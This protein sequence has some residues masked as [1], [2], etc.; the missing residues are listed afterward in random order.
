MGGRKGNKSKKKKTRTAVQKAAAARHAKFK[1][2]RVQTLGGKRT[3][4]SNAEKKRI[5]NAGYSVKGY[6]KAAPNKASGYSGT[7]G[8]SVGSKIKNPNPKTKQEVSGIG[9]VPDGN[10]YG[11]MIDKSP[12]GDFNTNTDGQLVAQKRYNLLN[13]FN[14]PGIMKEGDAVK[15]GVRPNVENPGPIDS[16]FNKLNERNKMLKE[17]EQSNLS[18]TGP[19]LAYAGNISDLGIGTTGIT[20]GG[21]NPADS[22]LAGYLNKSLNIGGTTDTNSEESGNT[23]TARAINNMTSEQL[24]DNYESSL[25]PNSFKGLSDGETTGVGPVA[26]GKAYAAGLNIDNKNIENRIRNTYNR[27]PLLPDVRLLTDKEIADKRVNAQNQLAYRNEMARFRRGAS[28]GTAAAVAP[29]AQT[30]PPEVPLLEQPVAGNTTPVQSGINNNNLM[31]IQQQSYLNN[32]AS[33]GMSPT[34]RFGSQPMMRNTFG[35]SFN[36]AYF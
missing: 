13:P 5:T 23:R 19:N 15:E 22:P 21:Y 28:G 3:N 9:P 35:T 7:S 25:D 26:S 27:I 4:F 6:S 14:I 16:I 8:V 20:E 1:Q 36:R 34:F 29:V 24:A 31:Q 33:L 12:L 18:I 17:L 30:P 11:R 10:V 32:L 2:T